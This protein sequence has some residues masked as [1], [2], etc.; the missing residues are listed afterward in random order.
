MATS[1]LSG[2][3]PLT[4]PGI[5]AAVSSYNPGA[6]ALGKTVENVFRIHYVGRS[7]VDVA[8]RLQD[9]VSKWYPEFKFGYFQTAQAAFEKEC[10]LYH[11]F[12]PPDNLVHPA[13]PQGSN[14]KCPV[15]GYLG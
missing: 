6:Y 7:D 2:P 4:T 9:H 1:G 3:Y 11:N 14:H 13:K 12:S 15:C 5:L 10:H 8:T